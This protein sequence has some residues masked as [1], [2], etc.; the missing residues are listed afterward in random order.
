ML[1]EL[2]QRLGQYNYRTVRQGFV[3]VIDIAQAEGEGQK[4]QGF[5][6]G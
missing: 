5:L 1:T 6:I 2:V 4:E 3:A